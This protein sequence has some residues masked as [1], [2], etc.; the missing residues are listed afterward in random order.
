MKF[1]NKESSQVNRL[2]V[3][4]CNPML[5]QVPVMQ[6][7]NGAGQ[8]QL[9]YLEDNNNGLQVAQDNFL[10]HN[11]I[12]NLGASF[13]NQTGRS[14]RVSN[15]R[16]NIKEV[17][18]L[19]AQQRKQIIL[20]NRAPTAN[21]SEFFSAD[22]MVGGGFGGGQFDPYPLAT[23]RTGRGRG[24]SPLELL[25]EQSNNLME[26]NGIRT[27]GKA[28][29]GGRHRKKDGSEKPNNVGV[30]PQTVPGSI[31]GMQKNGDRIDQTKGQGGLGQASGRNAET[32]SKLAEKSTKNQ[33]RKDPRFRQEETQPD[34]MEQEVVKLA[35][36]N[37]NKL[38]SDQD[39]M[40]WL[41]VEF[42]KQK[43]KVRSIAK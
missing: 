20:G 36:E 3:M 33:K 18:D 17:P 37:F 23:Q 10:K 4:D 2:E 40:V 41:L 6:T 28:I 43:R 8:N 21:N 9:F 14:N 34:W 25:P 32:E 19:L 29:A 24:L 1:L 35:T 39:T 15:G 13:Q 22:R 11:V 27:P 26:A 30:R 7:I 5:F 12:V 38:K 16:I 42:D 31:A